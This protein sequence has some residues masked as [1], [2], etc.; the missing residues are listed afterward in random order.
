[1]DT[2]QIENKEYPK[3]IYVVIDANGELYYFLKPED[4]PIY[5]TESIKI[6]EYS[7]KGIKTLKRFVVLE[8]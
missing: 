5:Y 4:N 8:D 6:M 1:M 3:T 2:V 7:V